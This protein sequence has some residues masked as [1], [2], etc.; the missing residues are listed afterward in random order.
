MAKMDRW[1]DALGGD[2]RAPT[3]RRSLASLRINTRSWLHPRT[4]VDWRGELPRG[5]QVAL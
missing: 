5:I 3:D 4:R 1:P 2:N